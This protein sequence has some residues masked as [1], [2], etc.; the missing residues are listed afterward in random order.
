LAPVFVAMVVALGAWWL[1]PVVG[2]GVTALLFAAAL[3]QPLHA[4]AN[5]ADVSTPIGWRALPYRFSLYAP[6]VVLYGMLEALI[7]NWSLL[8]LRSERRVSP[9]DGSFVLTSFWV[10]VTRGGVL[11]ATISRWIPVGWIYVARP[12]TLLVTFQIAARVH[13]ATGGILAFGLA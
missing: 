7:D 3:T 8:Y 13:D 9:R 4:S 2:A 12:I 10:V 11:I 1:L 6:A 5:A